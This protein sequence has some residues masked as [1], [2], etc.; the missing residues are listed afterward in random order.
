MLASSLEP[1]SLCQRPSGRSQ[2]PTV[3]EAHISQSR[4]RRVSPGP[5]I[6][7]VD[8]PRRAG[9]ADHL[10]P[11][12]SGGSACPG[13]TPGKGRKP[14]H[15]ERLCAAPQRHGLSFERPMPVRENPPGRKRNPDEHNSLVKRR[16]GRAGVPAAAENPLIGARRCRRRGPWKPPTERHTTPGRQKEAVLLQ[17]I[18]A[19]ACAPI[20]PRESLASS[21]R[22]MHAELFRS[23]RIPRPLGA[24]SCVRDVRLPGVQR[25]I[26]AHFVAGLGSS[27]SDPYRTVLC[28]RPAFVASIRSTRGRL[29]AGPADTR[30]PTCAR[31]GSAFPRCLPVCR[32]EA[33]VTS[34][35]I[36][37]TVRLLQ[38][39]GS[40][41]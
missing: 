5:G 29:R 35:C 13:V 27:F 23:G 17:S 34:N 30:V 36:C 26:C 4:A 9:R 41:T 11:V 12:S 8:S 14:N 6:R 40:R 22:N 38:T 16:H 18:D 33:S 21:P 19:H 39:H 25:R 1:T 10:S 7:R 20:A 28:H 24:G 32:P 3:R 31:V 37:C 2:R 15:L